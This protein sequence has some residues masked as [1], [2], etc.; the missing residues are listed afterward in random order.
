MKKLFALI[1]ALIVI[2][3]TFSSCGCVDVGGLFSGDKNLEFVLLDDG[4]YGVK[5]KENTD[6][7][8]IVIPNKYRGK[9][10]TQILPNG[11]EKCS[12]LINITIP[13]SVTGIGEKAFY[14]C[15][16]LTS[17]TIPNSLTTIGEKA[18]YNCKKLTNITLPDSVMSIGGKAFYNCVKLTN[19]TIPNGVTS[20]RS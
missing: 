13:D 2:L 4:T 5:A 20:I 7:E 3:M 6:F 18:F 11:F 19:I 9:T 10:V 17:V 8:E 12:S 16:K 15:A 1:L 14:N